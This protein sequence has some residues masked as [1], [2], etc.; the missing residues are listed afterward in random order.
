MAFAH[1]PLV[2]TDLV[3][4]ETDYLVLRRLGVGAERMFL[5]Q[6]VAGVPLREPVANGDLERALEI[7]E[8][9]SD[10]ALGLTDASLMAI[11]ERL[12]TRRVLTLDVRHFAPFRD[13]KG[14]PFELLP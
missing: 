5:E 10:Q 14:R 13:S 9:Y 12:D 4:A 1:G 3:L 6:L 11:A 2:T 7:L 8:Q